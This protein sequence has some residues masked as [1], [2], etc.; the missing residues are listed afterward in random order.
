MKLNQLL[1][2]CGVAAALILSAGTVS[3][4]NDNGGPG[5]GPGGGFRNMDPAQR[6]QF[7]INNI[8]EQ[9]GFTND[10]DWNAVQPL[11]QKVTDAQREAMSGRFGGMGRMFRNRGGDQGGAGGPGGGR[12]G[13]APQPSPEAEALQ[14]AIDDNSPATQIKAALAKY[15][16]AQKAK[17]AKLVQS[18]DDL[19]KVLTVKQEAQATLLGLLQ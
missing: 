16:A 11:I 19:R 8:R 17:Q 7:F 10:T 18:Q 9:L 14:K 5:G 15:E 4:Q 3:A 13:F 2:I 12:G 1:T 6:Q